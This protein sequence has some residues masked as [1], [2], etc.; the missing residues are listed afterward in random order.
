MDLDLTGR[1]AIV[2]GAS[3]GIGLAITSALAAEGVFVIAGA[4]GPSAELGDLERGRSG[5]SSWPP[6]WPSRTAPSLLVDAAAA[7]GGI[8]ILVNNIGATTPRVQGFL[9]V[10]DEQWL[11]SITLNL[12]AAVRTTRAVLP[13]MVAAG[14]GCIVTVGSVNAFLPD[15]AGDRLQRRQ[16]RADQLQQVAVEGVRRPG[17]SGSTRSAPDRWPPTSGSATTGWRRPWRCPGWRSGS[18]GRARRGGQRH[19]SFHPAAGGGRPRGVP[20][21]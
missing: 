10:T 1:T 19:R 8:D 4:R 5:A 3:K 11:T 2:T 20:R 13:M 15:P 18:G 17:R 12:M 14:R 21:Q 6:I 9:S 7:R 16:G